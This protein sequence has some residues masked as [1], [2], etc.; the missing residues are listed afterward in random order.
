M[1]SAEL[2]LVV[3]LEKPAAVTP[4]DLDELAAAAR[5]LDARIGV[6]HV[7][8]FTP[9]WQTVH[10]VVSSGTIGRLV[11]MAIEENIGY[12]HFAHSY[13]RG[14]WR[15]ADLASPMVLA[16][17][18]HDLDLIRWLA[19]GPPKTVSSVGGLSYFTAENAPPDAP[20]RCLDGCPHAETCAFYAPRFYVDRL[21]DVQGWPVSLLGPDTSPAG[22][23]EALRTGPYGRCV[24]R[25]DNDVADHQQ[26][27]ME[28]AGGG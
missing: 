1:A 19:G 22:R 12:W 5:R 26:T 17:T 8:R 13:V 2:G 27:V 21:R 6:G 10:E 7:L 4:D 28:F 25:G 24:F 14:I 11:T 23:V 15:R 3:L 18:C 20:D 16:K 9:F